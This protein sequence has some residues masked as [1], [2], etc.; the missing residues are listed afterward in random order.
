M[1]PV[2]ILRHAPTEG[3][4]YFATYLTR[5]GIPWRVIKIDAGDPVP[6]DPQ[7]FS[8]MAF[9]GGPMSV[10]DD[11]PWI[12]PAL[13]LI[14]GAVT[15]GIPTVGH[16]LGGQLMAKAMGGVV[17]RNPVKEIGWGRVEI[18]G[19]PEA[20]HWFGASLKSF[21]SFHWHGETFSIPPGAVR[22]ASSPYCENQVFALG[23]H[24][25]M[26]CHVEMT[27]ELIRAWC[28]DWEKEVQALAARVSSVQTPSEMT[29]A[30]EDKARVLNAVADRLYDRWTAGLKGR[31]S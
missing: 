30:I 31:K 20:E 26:Q 28:Q 3:P 16:C 4:G 5:R 6:D 14:R 7:A 27:P 25:G 8:G 11:L 22:L 1:K 15:A 21:D 29:H 24:L 17:M 18:L 12:A 9:M 23:P 2:A 10:N 13:T 19:N